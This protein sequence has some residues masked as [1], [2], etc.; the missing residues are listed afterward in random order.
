MVKSYMNKKTKTNSFDSKEP[1]QEHLG[2]IKL[3]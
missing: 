1:T 3:I 2:K